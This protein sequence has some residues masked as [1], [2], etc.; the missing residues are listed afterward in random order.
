MS[1]ERKTVDKQKIVLLNMQTL[2]MDAYN[3][4]LLMTTVED[5]SVTKQIFESESKAWNNASFEDRQGF[6]EELAE[7]QIAVDELHCACREVI[8]MFQNLEKSKRMMMNGVSPYIEELGDLE[9]EEDY[10]DRE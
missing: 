8:D 6:V 4:G 5:N 3:Q 1:F 2:L 10:S 7:L 9:E